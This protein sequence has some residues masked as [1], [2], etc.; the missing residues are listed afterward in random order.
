MPLRSLPWPL[1]RLRNGKVP[2]VCLRLG[3]G[4]GLQ[5][6]DPG[7]ELLLLPI[8]GAFLHRSK[9]SNFFHSHRNTSLC[10]YGM[11]SFT[12]IAVQQDAASPLT[13]DLLTDLTPC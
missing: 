5:V 2:E 9:V 10:I 3:P 8:A 13:G 7:F 1:N 11:I 12:M 6:P 4:I